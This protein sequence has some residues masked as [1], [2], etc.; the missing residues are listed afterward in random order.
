MRIESIPEEQSK[1][2]II[3]L[4]KTIEPEIGGD[5]ESEGNDESERMI[6]KNMKKFYER[7]KEGKD[8]TDDD[9]VGEDIIDPEKEEVTYHIREN[10]NNIYKIKDKEKRT[11]EINNYISEVIE[12]YE[13]SKKSNKDFCTIVDKLD[14]FSFYPGV[15]DSWD[16]KQVD[17]IIEIYE[18]NEKNYSELKNPNLFGT[19]LHEG[20]IINL[21]SDTFIRRIESGK[22]ISK[23]FLD[24]IR[25]WTGDNVNLMD[26]SKVFE[27]LFVLINNSDKIDKSDIEEI[28]NDLIMNDYL[29]SFIERLSYN[30]KENEHDN[31]KLLKLIE[32]LNYFKN[33]IEEQYFEECTVKYN[34]DRHKEANNNYF[35]N[36]KIDQAL[37]FFHKTKSVEEKRFYLNAI[38]NY[39]NDFVEEMPDMSE[40]DGNE[41]EDLFEQFKYDVDTYQTEIE[42]KRRRDIYEDADIRNLYDI[43]P[44]I[45][46]YK[47]YDNKEEEQKEKEFCFSKIND[48]YGIIYTPEGLIDSFFELDKEDIEKDDNEKIEPERLNIDD[49]LEKE[50]FKKE[51][52]SEGKYKKMVLTYKT[53]IELPMREKIEGEFDIEL[54]NF[55]IREQVQFVNFLS[56][57][58]VE[59]VE[60]VKEFL[61]QSK[62]FEAKNNRI[63]SFLSLESGEEM[64]KKILDIGEKLEPENADAIFAKYAEIIDLT[65]KSR[66][67]LEN[68]FKNKKE[69]SDEEIDKI[70]QNLMKKASCVLTDFAEKIKDGEIID[71]KKIIMLLENYIIDLILTSSI[72]KTLKK[73]TKR[74]DVDIEDF[75]GVAF[76]KSTIGE[77]T[78]NGKLMEFVDDIYDQTE[79]DVVS[80]AEISSYFDKEKPL[81]SETE[82]ESVKKIIRMI[83]I[84]WENYEKTPKL[85]NILVETFKQKLRE[86]KENINICSLM[87]NDRLYAFCRFDDIGDGKKHAASLNVDKIMQKSAIGRS[88]LKKCIEIEE[89]DAVIIAE[90]SFRKK[91]GSSYL[92]D[93]GFIATEVYDFEG[94][95]SIRIEKNKNNSYHYKS[96]SQEDIIKEHHKK[97][98]NN[99]FKASSKQFILKFKENNEECLSIAKRLL[100]E[101]YIMSRYFFDKGDI[102]NEFYCA[103]EKGSN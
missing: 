98:L 78:N 42:N 91:V 94:E 68:L 16:Q 77:M 83:E 32:V 80:E 20:N 19:V 25:Y 67:E 14:I 4:P 38:K 69:I 31:Y 99:K 17:K 89:E 65:E 15:N 82:K 64:G 92:E 35:A 24:Q 103:F 56:S 2:S 30:L 1:S 70:V 28:A 90:C 39:Y 33:S 76:E 63:R 44:A 53:L 74:D 54:K 73:D 34:L 8:F 75:E 47:E 6:G 62:D 26:S 84:Y 22:K 102:N 37:E 12:E 72:F 11:E 87:K 95:P 97:F 52:M 18:E 88:F 79:N 40:K 51:N 86:E 36:F 60:R 85:Q 46:E 101:G 10:L 5:V 27:L 59:E 50:G 9:W 55:S 23:T 13:N 61:N 43:K 93:F 29:E 66:D 57:K 45:F 58:T 48:K 21:V 3:D 71:E 41:V 100:G 81:A 7:A 96:Y 49:I